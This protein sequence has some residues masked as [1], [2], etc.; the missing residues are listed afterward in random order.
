MARK[1]LF[2]VFTNDACKRNHAFLWAADLAKHGHQVRIV[3][4]GEGTQSLK[5]REGRFGELFE[6]ARGMGLV[7]GVC[8]AAS[9]GCR[10]PARDVTPIAQQLGLALLDGADGHAS[11][12]P[13]VRDG[14]EVVTF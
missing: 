2:V 7:A 14:Y 12:E 10:D 11:I 8:K 6:Q 13:F 1:L 3:L 5:E 9:A 4:E